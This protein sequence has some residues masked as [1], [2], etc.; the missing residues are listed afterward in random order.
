MRLSKIFLVLLAVLT[1]FSCRKD[2]S[3]DPIN[4]TTVGP[5]EVVNSY[6]IDVQGFVTNP[7]GVPLENVTVKVGDEEVITTESGTFLIEKLVA[8]ETGLF[9]SADAEGYFKGGSTVYSHANHVYNVNITLIPFNELIN[10]DADSGLDFVSDD[11]ARLKIEGETVVDGSGNQYTGTVDAYMYWIDPTAENMP[12]L[13]P[14][15]L[16]GLQDD[17]LQ[18]LRSFGMIGVELYGDAGQELNISEAEFANLSFPVPS[19]ILSDAPAEIELWHFNESSGLWDIEGTATLVNGAYEAIVPHFSWW[20]CDI[21]ADFGSVCFNLVNENGRAIGNLDLN[22]LVDNFGIANDWVGPTG[23][24]CNLVPLGEELTISILSFCGD[25]LVTQTIPPIDE[26]ETIEIVVPLG[27]NTSTELMVSGTV[28][29][30]SEGPITDGFVTMSIGAVSYLTYLDEDGNYDLNVVVCSDGPYDASVSAY[31]FYGLTSGATQISLL[32]QDVVADI[33]GCDEDLGDE[34]LIIASP[35]GYTFYETCVAHV[36]ESEVTIVAK[37]TID[38]LVDAVVLGIAGFGEGNYTGNFLAV[39]FSD[40]PEEQGLTQFNITS[41]SDV[42]GE[43][44]A[45][46][47][48]YADLVG[49]FVAVVQ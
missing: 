21:P 12:A 29:C 44:I 32:D 19:D 26:G 41:Y 14:G 9:L 34:V 39:S 8:P 25:V 35:D 20:N 23:V 2:Q 49:N 24:Y 22:L 4:V 11:G 6:T 47:F 45:G 37:I 10:F 36:S 17:E 7:D 16:V 31:D 5:F 28:T 1:I 42:P 43:K 15:P 40:F 38:D 18:S 46:S 33:D 30:G 48:E 13:S 3:G 27:A